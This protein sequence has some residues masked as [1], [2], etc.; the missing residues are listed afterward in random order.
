M[1]IFIRNYNDEV[2]ALV[3]RANKT[4]GIYLQK[5]QESLARTINSVLFKKA[6]TA[7]SYESTLYVYLFDKVKFTPLINVLV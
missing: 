3:D 4:N 1:I 6:A 5:D 7:G 2:R